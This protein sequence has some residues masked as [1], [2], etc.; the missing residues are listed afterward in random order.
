MRGRWRRALAAAAAAA[1]VLAGAAAPAQAEP[2]GTL[3]LTGPVA[4]GEAA[5]FGYGTPDPHGTNWI[6]VYP[7]GEGP[8]D[9]EYTEPSLAWTYAPEG[10]GRP[11]WTPAR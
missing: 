9:E 11:R 1:V 8:V 4:Q 5:T 10:E 3:A 7:Q 6:G 2:A